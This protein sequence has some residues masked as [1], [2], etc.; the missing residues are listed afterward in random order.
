MAKGGAAKGPSKKTVE[1][2]KAKVI[3]DK[4]FGLKNKK[5]KKVQTQIK[6]VK[7]TV[8]QIHDKKTKKELE[9]RERKRM[10]KLLEKKR[11]EELKALFKSVDEPKKEAQAT[12]ASGSNVEDGNAESKE[13]EKQNDLYEQIEEEIKEEEEM[14]IEDII[15]KERAKIVNGTPVTLESF[16]RWKQ[17]KMEQKKKEE[18]VRRRAALETGLGLTGRDLFEHN[19]SLFVDDEEAA[20]NEAYA[21]DEDVDQDL[22]LEDEGENSDGKEEEQPAKEDPDV[23]DPDTWKDPKLPKVLLQEYLV[24]KKLPLPK[25]ESVPL[26]NNQQGHF[27]KIILPHLNKEYPPKKVYPNK[28]NAEHAAALLAYRD[29]TKT[30]LS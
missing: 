11:E 28:K 4:T 25:Y 14:T 12:S 7:N 9:E 16:T 21:R 5:S 27:V 10:E 24:A 3:E 23:F 17:F 26:P 29:L 18:E 13:D 30:F 6:Q 22:F 8:N 1:K 2:A 19:K 20:E 15:E